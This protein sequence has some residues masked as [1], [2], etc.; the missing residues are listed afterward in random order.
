MFMAVSFYI[1]FTSQRNKILA[2]KLTFFSCIAQP[3]L[4]D[5]PK[6]AA[7]DTYNEYIH[8]VFKGLYVGLILVSTQQNVLWT[9]K[10]CVGNNQPLSL[11]GHNT[12]SVTEVEVQSTYQRLYQFTLLYQNQRPDPSDL[13]HHTPRAPRRITL[14]CTKFFLQLAL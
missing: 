8:A 10:Y 6:H 2:V 13:T 3:W 1:L 14:G 11:A 5:K 4:S 9:N 7:F 12:P